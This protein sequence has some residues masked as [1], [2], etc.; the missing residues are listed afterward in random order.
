[1]PKK[2]KEEEEEEEEVT[3]ISSTILFRCKHEIFD[4]ERGRRN[5]GV[6]VAPLNSHII[7]FYFLLK[8]EVYKNYKY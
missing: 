3:C 8:R 6:L 7:H 1:M 2:T 5:T 4:V